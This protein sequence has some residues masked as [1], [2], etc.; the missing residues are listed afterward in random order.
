MFVEKLNEGDSFL[1]SASYLMH[2]GSFS[3]VRKFLLDHSARIV[4]D[5][6]GIPLAMFDMSKW[7]VTPFGNY[8]EPIPTFPGM[9][10]PKMKALFKANQPAPI[11]FGIG[12]R[13]RPNQS[14]LLVATRKDVATR[15]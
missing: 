5:D 2:R 15:P 10:Q 1:K 6:S 4:Q 11:D 14:N 13:W 7:Q 3:Q 12:Y 9:Y 8:L